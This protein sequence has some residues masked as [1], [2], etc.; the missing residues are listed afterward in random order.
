VG[1][2]T[3]GTVSPAEW[4]S[5]FVLG[6]VADTAT[7]PGLLKTAAIQVGGTVGDHLANQQLLT[8][9]SDYVAQ[10]LNSYWIEGR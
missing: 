4:L 3:D 2:N 1:A 5:N 6:G 8:A 7:S 9:E 10:N